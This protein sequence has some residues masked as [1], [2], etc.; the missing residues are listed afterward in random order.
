MQGSSSLP[1]SQV[2]A[3][4]QRVPLPRARGA[5]DLTVLLESPLS[6]AM[7]ERAGA[8]GCQPRELEQALMTHLEARKKTL[9][10][11]LGYMN[12]TQPGWVEQ[13][14]AI[15]HQHGGMG[16]GL[17]FMAKR[18]IAH[19]IYEGEMEWR[20]YL[21]G[22]IW[23]TSNMH[24]PLTR[25]WVQQEA[26]RA[27]GNL[28]G[29][30]PFFESSAVTKRDPT[31][32]E[33]V[34]AIANIVDPWSQFEAKEAK[35]KDVLNQAIMHAFIQGEQ[36]VK[37]VFESRVQFYQDIEEVACEPGSG[38]KPKPIIAQD[39]GYI[40]PNDKFIEAVNPITGQAGMVLARDG[41]TPQPAK[42]VFQR[43]RVHKKLEQFAGARLIEVPFTAFLCPLACDGVDRSDTH[44][45]LYTESVV[46]LVAKWAQIDTGTGVSP[47]VIKDR[48]GRLV[49]EFQGKS[50]PDNW[51]P[52]QGARADLAEN[53]YMLGMDRAEPSMTVAEGM[54][55][56]DVLQDANPSAL[57]VLM[58]DQTGL[59]LYYDWAP[60]ALRWNK[61]LSPHQVLRINPV[62]GRWHGRGQV[63]QFYKTQENIDLM[64]NRYNV[65]QT[66]AGRIDIVKRNAIY[67]LENQPTTLPVNGGQVLTIKDQYD[68]REAIYSHYLQETKGSDL[69]SILQL[70]MQVGTN[71]SGVA[72]ANDAQAAGLDQQDTATGTNNI[73]ANGEELTS[74]WT[75]QL[76]P[77]VEGALMAF[78]K[79]STETLQTP[80]A[81]TYF[82]GD[83]QIAA[84]LTPEQVANLELLVGLTMTK[85]KA[86]QVNEE[87][88]GAYNIVKDYYM[89][90]PPE[91]QT[92]MAGFTRQ[93]LKEAFH[94]D[95]ADEIIVP[96]MELAAKAQQQQGAG[97]PGALMGGM[98]MN[99]P[100]TPPTNATTTTSP[101][102]IR[103]GSPD[104]PVN[105]AAA[106]QP[107]TAVAPRPPEGQG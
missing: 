36:V 35:V 19:L 101:E 107:R 80:R 26:A 43:M 67:E 7:R 89:G 41:R 59:P 4:A 81:F 5:G 92:A 45:H 60:N 15:A 76:Q 72:S 17:P 54:T 90:L 34:E 39:G 53:I 23:A 102:P 82:E 46:N 20:Q 6:E 73:A 74:V 12:Y 22:G 97:M 2:A 31:M 98:P 66:R 61:G 65:S 99:Q 21:Y 25:R 75:R 49:H 29:V 42:L 104:A 3:L 86:R 63:E 100:V 70:F 85:F 77:T 48:I 91:V 57:F 79:M 8:I 55:W 1:G 103:G 96:M 24:L 44:F 37:P 50:D 62:Q 47:E 71:A 51:R 11:D 10:N 30:E 95:D 69:N 64:L 40:Y 78:L 9:K 93:W 105:I 68:P 13:A 38:R 28:L 14:R 27:Q 18:H 58:D 16:Y 56:F 106:T 32:Q 52:D 88:Q 87:K 33:Q 84:E 94:V 83:T